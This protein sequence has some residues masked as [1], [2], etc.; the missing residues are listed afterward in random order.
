MN[1]LRFKP[2]MVVNWT[3]NRNVDSMEMNDVILTTVCMRLIC[4]QDKLHSLTLQHDAAG[5]G[6]EWGNK[7]QIRGNRVVNTW[8]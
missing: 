4:I 3:I 1:F 8:H 6:C 2:I 5:D 7:S